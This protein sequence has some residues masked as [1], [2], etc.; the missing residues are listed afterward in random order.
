[1]AVK[2]RDRIRALERAFSFGW[3]VGAK[4]KR[5]AKSLKRAAWLAFATHAELSTE[6]VHDSVH[7]AADAPAIK[8]LDGAPK[9]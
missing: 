7:E 5:L 4:G 1:M 8:R 2:R 3:N 6:S 9:K